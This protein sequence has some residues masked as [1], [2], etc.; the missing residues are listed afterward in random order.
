[1]T[2]EV[3]Q[4]QNGVPPISWVLMTGDDQG[5]VEDVWMIFLHLP[6]FTIDQHRKIIVSFKVCYIFCKQI[7]IML[8]C[9]LLSNL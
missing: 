1:M 5:I 8:H 7:L 9:S 2:N 6:T 3:N 4:I